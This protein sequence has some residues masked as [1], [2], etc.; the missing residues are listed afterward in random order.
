ME[1]T[2]RT[3]TRNSNL[4]IMRILLMIAIIAH[5][6]VINSCVGQEYDLTSLSGEVFFLQI[7]AVLG[8]TAI[9]C[10][11]LVNGY[12]MVK[13]NATLKKF[14]KLYLEVKF[15]YIGTYLLLTAVG[16]ETFSVEGLK[17]AAL[18]VLYELNWLYTG[19]YLVFFLLI[20]L[21]NALAN[22][23]TQRQYRYALLLGV[24]YY[25]V[26]STFTGADTFSYLGWMAVMYLLGGYFSLYGKSLPFWGSLKF[27]A[28]GAAVVL[29][30]M[31]ASVL[32]IDLWGVERGFADYYYFV[33]DSHK[34]LALLCSV[35]LFLLFLWMPERR[36]R[37]INRI[38]A[39]M[40]GV[41]LIHSNGP[42]IRRLLWDQ[43]FDPKDLLGQGL[44]P[45]ALQAVTAVA[46]VFLCCLVI[47]QLRISFIEKPFF[48]WLYRQPW[49]KAVEEKTDELWRT[50]KRES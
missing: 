23:M 1:I 47:D 29:A 42:A 43:L 48:R 40:F 32:A 10:F 27:A 45:L 50:E 7:Y 19:T 26:V 9:N 30:L 49:M 16:Y 35:F 39:S 14:L 25:T 18:N 31:V 5:H 20:P 46:V 28:C 11:T 34:I 8:K 2:E 36:N 15:Y 33:H 3:R 13:S 6:Y 4:E 12:F 38:A 24:T 37:R 44:A 41:L 22:R 21:L 17:T